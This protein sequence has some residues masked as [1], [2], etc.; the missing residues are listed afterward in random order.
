MDD[1]EQM[2]KNNITPQLSNSSLVY[3]N[4]ERKNKHI[5]INVKKLRRQDKVKSITESR[6]EFVFLI[7]RHKA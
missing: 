6:M 2:K 4:I 1:T 5:D 7:T 3:L